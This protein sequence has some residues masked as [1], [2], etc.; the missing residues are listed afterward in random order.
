MDISHTLFVT[1]EWPLER[2]FFL[3]IQKTATLL[4]LLGLFGQE[5]SLDV[6]QYTSLGD[7]DT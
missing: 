4:G 2:P 5:Y 6:R 1:C 7:G 3:C